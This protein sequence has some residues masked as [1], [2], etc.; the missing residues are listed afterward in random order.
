MIFTLIAAAAL[1]TSCTATDG[2]TIR[3]GRERIRL[4]AID[5][6]EMPGHCQRGRK[7]A[8][9]DPYR[10]KQSLASALRAGPVRITRTG[11]DRYGRTLATVSA[12]RI[13]LSCH[14]LR[15][16]QAIYVRRWDDGSRIAR[17]CLR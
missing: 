11:K 9:G 17:T 14:Q 12:G 10:S 4:L 6:P 16:R 8:S 2:D 7:C 13:D 5:A 15:N 1:A 3:C